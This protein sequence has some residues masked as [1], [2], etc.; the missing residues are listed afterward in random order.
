MTRFYMDTSALIKH[1]HEEVGTD[2]VNRLLS[3]VL[4][5]KAQGLVSSLALPETISTLN[6]KKNN[7]LITQ[8]KFDEIISIFYEEMK[9]F[10]II[11]AADQFIVSSIPYILK[12]N[13]NSADAIHLTT[14]LSEYTLSKATG[15]FY[16]VCCDKRLLSAAKQEKLKTINPETIRDVA[17]I[18]I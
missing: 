11:S 1:Y 7:R 16:F 3:A 4:S 10:N 17:S 8:K 12:H 13:L 5:E 15:A 18:I 9:Y 2:A 14:A 6:H